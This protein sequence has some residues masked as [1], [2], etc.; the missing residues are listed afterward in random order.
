M[1]AAADNCNCQTCNCNWLLLSDIL[2]CN[3]L[4]LSAAADISRSL[5]ISGI[6][7]L[8]ACSVYLFC[9]HL[10]GDVI[11]L[12]KKGK[13]TKN[14]SYT[15]NLVWCSMSQFPAVVSLCSKKF[16]VPGPAPA[17]LTGIMKFSR[18]SSLVNVYSRFSSELISE[19]FYR[20]RP[21][22]SPAQAVAVNFSKISTAVILH[23]KLVVIWLLR[24]STV[25]VPAPA[26]AQVAAAAAVAP[27]PVAAA[28]SGKRKRE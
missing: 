9:P 26:P 18:I 22:P 13:K 5:S 4:Q 21:H 3:W 15:V 19:N 17:P 23:S 14:S 27:N 20:T 1:S 16:T 7:G 8:F 24:I 11:P 2:T 6:L 25:P 10:L 12:K 28:T